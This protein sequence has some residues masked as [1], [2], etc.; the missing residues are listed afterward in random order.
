MAVAGVLMTLLAGVALSTLDVSPLR[1]ALALLLVGASPLLL[2]NLLLSRFDLWPA[3]LAAAALAALLW[4]RDATGAVA[5]GAAI[6]T[7]LYPAVLVP[8]GIAWVWRRRGRRAAL[9]W[10]ALVVAVCAVVFLP[11]AVI[12]PGGMGHSFGV[13]LGRPL[14]IESLG[15]A[16]LIAAHH[17]AGVA[18]GLHTDHGSQNVVGGPA[19]VLAAVTTVV[20]VLGLCTVWLLFA[21][22]PAQ[23]RRLVAAAA[24][25]VTMFVAF[26]KVLSPQFMVWLIPLV[27]LVRSRAAP[28][29]YAA[30]LVL[31][32]FWFPKRYWQYA[33]DLRGLVS[34]TVLARD[35]VLVALAGVL[36]RALLTREQTSEEHARLDAL[37]RVR[38]QTD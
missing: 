18:I 27:P 7:K 12:A 29:L 11:F 16:V 24:A 9:A 10:T 22:G 8:L 35:L 3:A 1:A 14:Q 6:A 33:N 15:A 36:V 20:Q 37:A 30:A 5:L 4:E 34:W 26:G 25:A 17:L 38:P 2:G 13:Q 23:R 28:F 19:N 32:Q 31:T 21:R